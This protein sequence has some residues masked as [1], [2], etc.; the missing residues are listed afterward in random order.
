MAAPTRHTASALYWTSPLGKGCTLLPMDGGRGLLEIEIQDNVVIVHSRKCLHIINKE[1]TP[2]AEYEFTIPLQRC[3]I[4][5]SR[6]KQT[7]ETEVERSAYFKP[8]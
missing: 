6:V 5:W 4:E 3:Q 7:K 8:Q 1:E 2:L